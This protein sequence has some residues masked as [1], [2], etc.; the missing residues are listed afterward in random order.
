VLVAEIH[1]FTKASI[2]RRFTI[3]RNSNVLWVLGFNELLPRN[4]IV[5]TKSRKK[6]SL[7]TD[8]LIEKFERVLVGEF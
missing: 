8:A 1:V 4:L 2:E 3:E 5:P 6:A 7:S